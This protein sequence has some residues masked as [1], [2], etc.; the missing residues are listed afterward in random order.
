MPHPTF[1]VNIDIL[2]DK[3]SYNDKEWYYDFNQ[4]NYVEISTYLFNVNWPGVLNSS[5]I[6]DDVNNL[7]LHLHEAINTFVPVKCRYS[8]TYP[9]W[10]NKDVIEL[11]KSKKAAHKRYKTTRSTD[12][13]LLTN[14]K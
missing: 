14:F 8:S 1:Q 3:S 6:D 7:Y 2:S 12:D 10:F 9:R 13:Y 5:N 11:I 4:A